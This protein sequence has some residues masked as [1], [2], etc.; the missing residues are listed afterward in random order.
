[1]V[2]KSAKKKGVFDEEIYKRLGINNLILFGVHS[3]I[4]KQKKC[5]FED[6]VKEC[7]ALFPRAFNFSQLSQWPDARKLDRP[8][9]FL[10][11]RKLIKGDPKTFFSLTELGEKTVKD[12]VRFLTQKKLW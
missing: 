11:K 8:L 9:R 3:V 10:R 2:R 5:T 4:L 7:F 6:L 12:T 1:M